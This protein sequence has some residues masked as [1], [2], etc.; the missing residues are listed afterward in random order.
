MYL[1]QKYMYI[2]IYERVKIKNWIL[3]NEIGFSIRLMTNE[4]SVKWETE[5]NNE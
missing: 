3:L 1:L 2:Y 5:C 4:R